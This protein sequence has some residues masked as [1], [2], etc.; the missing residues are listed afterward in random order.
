M[1]LNWNY[2]VVICPTGIN[3]KGRKS[4]FIGLAAFH[5]NLYINFRFVMRGYKSELQ[6]TNEFHV[7]IM[8]KMAHILGILIKYF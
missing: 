1:V 4:I 6:L 3:K 2:L 8:L 7:T 5:H